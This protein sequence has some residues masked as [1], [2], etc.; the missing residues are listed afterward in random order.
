[1]RYFEFNYIETKEGQIIN[2]GEG[3]YYT[4]AEQNLTEVKDV[5]K[6]ILKNSN[7]IVSIPMITEIDRVTFLA[8][9]GN[10][11]AL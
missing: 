3:L 7:A 10:P 6:F 4:G 5:A 9:G 1:M 11:N 2:Q 8:K